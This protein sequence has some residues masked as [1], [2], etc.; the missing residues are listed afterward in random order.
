MKNRTASHKPGRGIAAPGVTRRT[1]L[2]GL[3]AATAF[4]IVAPHVLGGQG[5]I[6]PSDKTTLAGIG[7]GGQGSQNIQAFLQFPEIQVVAVCDVNRESGG[8]LS[9]NWTQG[10]EQ[11][12]A[13]GNRRGGWSTKPTPRTNPPGHPAA[14]EPTAISANCWPRKTSTR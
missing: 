6:A 12:T 1:F 5:H 11:R 3:S 2:G 13:G 8:Y 4:T 9:W 7:V 14:A 10:K